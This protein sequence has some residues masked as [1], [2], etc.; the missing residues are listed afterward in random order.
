[1]RKIVYTKHAKQRIL[2]RDISEQEI[3]TVLEF[4]DYTISYENKKKSIKRIHDREITVIFAD[5]NDYII[6]ITVY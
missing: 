1:M 4:P 5:K 6:I 2:E 3:K